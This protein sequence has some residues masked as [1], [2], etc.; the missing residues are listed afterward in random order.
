MLVDEGFLHD[1]ADLYLL[2][3]KTDALAVIPGLGKRSVEKL[4]AGIEASKSQ[5]L[6]RLLPALGIRFVG[7]RAGTLLAG[8]FGAM[9]RIEEAC[10]RAESGV[11]GVGEAM[12]GSLRQFFSS[13]AGTALMQRLRA[14]GVN[15]TEPKKAPPPSGSVSLAGKTVVVTGTLETMKRKEAEALVAALGG[16]ASSSVTK[17][18]SFVV[19]G[20]KA[21]SK[22][23]KAQSLGIEVIDEQEF[24]RRTGGA[25][26]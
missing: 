18:T 10:Q 19:A 14:V 2:K 20:E 11:D 21:G 24:L 1:F 15:M 9:D 7:R 5:P 26:V 25:K 12:L 13:D 17:S 6:S 4:L 16:K 22:L 3:G 23:T 8:E